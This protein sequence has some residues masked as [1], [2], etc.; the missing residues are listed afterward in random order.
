MGR[1]R[2]LQHVSKRLALAGGIGLLAL[3]GCGQ[4]V[5]PS[6]PTEQFSE[7]VTQTMADGKVTFDEYEASYRSYVGCLNEAGYTVVENPSD[8]NGVFNYA[9]PA[10][11][12]SDGVDEKCYNELFGPVDAAYQV[13]NE[14]TSAT[15]EILRACLTDAGITPAESVDEMLTQ[16]EAEGMDL[17]ACAN[18][19]N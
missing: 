11:A 5:G 19:G 15:A 6:S 18:P 10:Q 14:D 2:V 8:S 7:Q 9:V 16:L 3:T 4:T 1:P 17:V 13:A 12:V